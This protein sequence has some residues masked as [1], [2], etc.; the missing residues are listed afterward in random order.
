[1]RFD[2]VSRAQN[3]NGR[4]RLPAADDGGVIDLLSAGNPRE[5]SVWKNVVVCHIYFVGSFGNRWN[6]T[7]GVPYLTPQM[8]QTAT[9]VKPVEALR[10]QRGKN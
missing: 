8:T 2:Y 10:E 4:H 9:I 6:D 3:E 7:F 1:V 5:P